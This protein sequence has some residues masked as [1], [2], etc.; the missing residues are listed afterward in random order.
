MPVFVIS[1]DND[2]VCNLSLD[3]QTVIIIEIKRYIVGNGQYQSPVAALNGKFSYKFHIMRSA[4]TAQLLEVHIDAVQSQADCC[5]CHVPH[6]VL[7]A[8]GG[9]QHIQSTD[10]RSGLIGVIKI[11][12]HA[13]YL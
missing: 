11:I 8:G 3:I 7:P 6:K 13:P 9:G 1:H 10:G 2:I 5:I 4:V 12:H